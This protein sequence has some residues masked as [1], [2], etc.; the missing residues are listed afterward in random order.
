MS[1]SMKQRVIGWVILLVVAGAFGVQAIRA[2]PDDASYGREA[3][4]WSHAIP[5][6]WLRLTLVRDLLRTE[7]WHDHTVSRSNAPIGGITSPW[8]RPLDAVI[9]A[10][11]TVMT[12]RIQ[13]G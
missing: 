9:I 13:R 11:S 1:P 10:L 5:I 3:V 2:W 4:M 12:G 8:T 7:Q 6:P